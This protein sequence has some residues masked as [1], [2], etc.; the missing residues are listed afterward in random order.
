MN[1]VSLGKF[2]G[3]P[4]EKMLRTMPLEIVSGRGDTVIAVVVAPGEPLPE[5][6]PAKP[7]E[8][9]PPGRD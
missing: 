4:V 5:P 3:M 6:T 8:H 2:R 1:Q 9:F 7:S